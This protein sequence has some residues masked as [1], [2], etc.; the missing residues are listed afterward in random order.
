MTEP[1]YCQDLYTVLRR[2]IGTFF[3][4]WKKGKKS[5]GTGSGE[6]GGCDKTVTFSDFNNCIP[7]SDVCD[8]ALS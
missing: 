7:S 5:H 8:E 6:Y 3:K 1:R 2:K 4:F